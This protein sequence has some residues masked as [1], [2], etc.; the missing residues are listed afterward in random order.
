MPKE[1]ILPVEAVVN[2]TAKTG[3]EAQATEAPAAATTP[4]ETATQPAVAAAKSALKVGT[5]FK[6]SKSKCKY[7]VIKSSKGK[8]EVSCTSYYG[9]AKKV[10]IPDTVKKKGITYKVTSIGAKA[11]YKNKKLT[12]VTIPKYVTKIGAKAFYGCAKL[13]RITFKTKKLAAIG[14]KAFTGIKKKAVFVLPKKKWKAY[15]KLLKSKTG[16]KKTMK[17]KKA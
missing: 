1:A 7:K 16:Y 10:T 4:A 2:V 6:D 15:K 13:Q 12:Q 17:I 11:F 3:E 8:Y 9:K 5:V 14:K